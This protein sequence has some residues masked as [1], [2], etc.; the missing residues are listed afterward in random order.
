VYK[1]LPFFS[2]WPYPSSSSYQETYCLNNMPG[3]VTPSTSEVS[4]SSAENASDENVSTNSEQTQPMLPAAPGHLNGTTGLHRWTSLSFDAADREA[5]W[6]EAIN[7][8]VRYVG[9]DG[10]FEQDK[11]FKGFF[12]YMAMRFGII[13]MWPSQIGISDVVEIKVARYGPGGLTR[14]FSNGQSLRSGTTAAQ[15]FDTMQTILLYA[16]RLDA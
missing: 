3:S 6:L 7:Q 11:S 16:Y 10:L 4:S 13:M 1:Y 12:F 14:R 5:T 15:L 9:V 2:N 8:E